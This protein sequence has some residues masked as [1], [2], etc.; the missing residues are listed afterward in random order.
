MKFL[1]HFFLFVIIIVSFSKNTFS[2]EEYKST[3]LIISSYNYHSYTL[4]NTIQDLQNEYSLLGGK[5][6]FS[7]ESMNCKSFPDAIYWKDRMIKILEKY[8][9]NTPEMIILIGQEA[10][11]S[12]ISITDE[13]LYSIPVIG[14]MV[15]QNAVL[16]PDSIPNL[17]DWEPESIDVLKDTKNF[18]LVGGILSE[19]DIE[20]NINLILD[21]YPNSENIALL[22]DNTYGGVALQAHVR[23]RMSKYPELNLIQ[24]D[25]RKYSIYTIVQELTNLP[26]NTVILLGTW[27]VDSNDGYFVKNSIYPLR[28]ANTKIPAFSVSSL[29]LGYWAIGGYVPQYKPVGKEI[30]KQVFN[31][32]NNSHQENFKIEIIPNKYEF[33]FK[34]I[35]DAG[36][37]FKRLPQ[38][39]K[40]INK[41]ETLWEKYSMQITLTI[42]IFSIVFLAFLLNLY[43]LIRTRKLNN[44]LKKSQFEL[45]L[46]KEKAEESDKLKTA[47]LANMS[48][49][50]RTP[51]NAIV[52]FANILA[53]GDCDKDETNEYKNV[54]QINTDLLLILINNILDFSRLEIDSVLFSIEDCD[55]VNLCKSA[56][57]NTDYPTNTEIIF[58][59][60]IDSYFV[61]T[62]ISRLKQVL[63]NLISNAL[64][65]TNEGKVTLSFEIEQEKNRVLF[66]VTDTG[67]G[68]PKDK[69]NLV[70]ERF[71]KLNT[72]TQGTGLGLP[73]CKLII[74]KLGGDIWIDDTYSNGAKLVFTHP[75]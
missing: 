63:S 42:V 66:S 21:F 24:L 36:I 62:D 59:P 14:A 3:I 60:P 38:N 56:I 57:S 29:G 20:K 25:G 37:D 40:F 50:I 17:A 19:Y 65:F 55:I 11:T 35:I 15:S 2:Q 45:K 12:F 51:L 70:F 32:F 54:I 47:F 75:I 28:D 58:T 71:E 22:T 68:I 67:D 33:D 18:N 41:D 4:S 64:K 26:E 73:I 7:V 46:S 49:E 74:N 23:N 5:H 43:F 61:R 10:W 31:Y 8:S 30:A 13:R 1:Y 44:K 9:N 48:H 27:L 52:G 39:V 6:N 72:H 69:Q 53:L 16:L 34:K